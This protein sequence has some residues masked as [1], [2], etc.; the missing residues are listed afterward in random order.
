[1]QLNNLNS[2]GLNQIYQLITFKSTKYALTCFFLIKR[3][4][5]KEEIWVD[6]IVMRLKCS[7]TRFLIDDM[8]FD[9][10]YFLEYRELFNIKLLVWFNCTSS[11]KSLNDCP[12]YN[13]FIQILVVG[14]THKWT[15]LQEYFQF[16]RFPISNRNGGP[17][18]FILGLGEK[19][20]SQIVIKQSFRENHRW[21]LWC[22]LCK[23]N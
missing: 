3:L 15:I 8:K 17:D 12:L 14:L 16:A 23:S 4:N 7:L 10:N 19:I 11:M 20:H 5:L 6:C 9:W 18:K 2:A 13:T 22:T 21:G 1:M